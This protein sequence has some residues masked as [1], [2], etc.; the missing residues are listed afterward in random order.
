MRRLKPE[1][2]KSFLLLLPS[3]IAVAI[4]VYVF[5]G[6]T[7]Y[8]SISNWRTLKADLSVRQPPYQTYVDMFSMPRFQAD[9]RNTVVFTVLFITMAILLGLFLAIL[10]DHKVFGRAVFRNVILFPY[11]LS[12]VVTGVVWRWLFNPETGVNLFL[13]IFGINPLLEQLGFAPLQPGWIT[14]PDVL[15]GVNNALAYVWPA[16]GELQIELGIPAAMIPV[17][18]AATWQLSGFVMAMYLGGMSTISHE[19]REAARIDGATEAQV[20]WHVIIP[21]LKP[22][23]VGTV[24]ILLHVSLKIF[25]LVWTMTG[26]GPGFATDVPA[27][28]VFEQMFRANRFNLAS[29]AAIIMLLLVAAVII[30][31]LTHTLREE[32]Q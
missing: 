2:V 22:I 12:F 15:L 29:A 18:L 10:L 24:V 4:F 27:I 20:Y 23:T 13:D 32:T 7:F 25:D 14:N 17:A 11:S 5:I 31:Y 6:T 3:L 19:I 9:L 21:I 28:F 1:S 8:V 30:P 16:V 26:V